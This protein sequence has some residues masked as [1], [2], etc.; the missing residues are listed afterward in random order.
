[1]TTAQPPENVLRLLAETHE[2]TCVNTEE[3]LCQLF[4]VRPWSALS[5]EEQESDLTRERFLCPR[6]DLVFGSRAGVRSHR[7]AF[8]AHIDA[9]QRRSSRGAP[10]YGGEAPVFSSAANHPAERR[11]ISVVPKQLSLGLSTPSSL[12][13]YPAARRALSVARHIRAAPA[14]EPPLP[15]RCNWDVPVSG[16]VERCALVLGHGGKCMAWPSGGPR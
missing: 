7:A 10:G 16:R 2:R 8:R 14:H 3:R 6:C 5:P 9:A 12:P 11:N 13:A 15:A 4:G 1:M